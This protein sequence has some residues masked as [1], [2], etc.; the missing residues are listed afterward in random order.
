MTTS[1]QATTALLTEHFRYT[2]LTLLDDIINTVNELVFRAVNAVEEGFANTSP[3]VLGFDASPAY[4][5][6]L[7]KLKTSSQREKVLQQLKNDETDAGIVK[8]E[9]LLNATVDKDF[10]KF[11]IYTL[12]NIL[13]VGHEEEGLADWVQLDHYKGLDF[14][15]A[16]AEDI[17]PEG[18]Q[19]QRKKMHETQKLNAMLKA[20]E[21]RNRAVLDQLQR[22][23]NP[24]QP[25]SSQ[26]QS[27]AEQAGPS[28][29]LAFLASSQPTSS[30]L[31]DAL[32][33]LPALRQLLDQLKSSLTSLPQARRTVDEGSAD[34]QRQRYIDS[35]S[36]R[37]LE[38]RGINVGSESIPEAALSGNRL[39]PEEVKGLETVVQSLSSDESQR[40]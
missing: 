36:L 24:S 37:A 3:E 14:N 11:E 29:N 27:Q 9:S 25:G 31:Q 40:H 16:T 28:A 38:K 8:L 33:Q 1:Q 22:L 6:Q 4:A 13:S 34:T 18:L 15:A 20:E 19:L 17:T 5:A 35:Q 10:D 39:G 21:A 7:P 12:R 23:L 2:P 26:T 30:D 32:G